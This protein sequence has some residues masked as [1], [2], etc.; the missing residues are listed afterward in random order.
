MIDLFRSPFLA[1][2]RRTFRPGTLLTGAGGGGAF[3]GAGGACAQ[4]DGSPA[5][6]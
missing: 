5:A 3:Q 4:R 1:A 2:L 6:R